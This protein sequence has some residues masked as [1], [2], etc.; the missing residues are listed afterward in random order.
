MAKKTKTMNPIKKKKFLVGTI[1]FYSLQSLAVIGVLVTFGVMLD[2]LS[3]SLDNYERSLEKYEA[4]EVFE[5]GDGRY[6]ILE[7]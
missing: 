5:I 4:E 3:T 6:L 1:I 7:A 2:K